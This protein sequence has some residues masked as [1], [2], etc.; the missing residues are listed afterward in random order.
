M[1]KLS[2]LITVLLFSAASAFADVYTVCSGKAQVARDSGKYFLN[3]DIAIQYDDLEKNYYLYTKANM[4]NT[5]ILLS[6][7]DL[8]KIR[9]ALT[10]YKEWVKI[11]K[12]H[13]VEMDKEIP[14]SSIETKVFW[15]HGKDQWHTA[16]GFKLTLKAV[17][18]NLQ[19]HYLVIS[20]NKVISPQSEYINIKLDPLYFNEVN[21]EALLAALQK[22]K[23]ESVKEEYNKKKAAQDLFQ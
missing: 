19:Q 11:A 5:K 20:S 6:E 9:Y 17:S 15:E 3:A 16:S 12:E 13:N 2:F 14:D 10:K 4:T 21:A 1:K 7:N 18:Q 8:E 23:I 22:E